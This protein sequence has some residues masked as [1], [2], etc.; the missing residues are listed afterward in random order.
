M[1]KS[2]LNS[3]K[4]ELVAQAYLQA[5][6]DRCLGLTCLTYNVYLS[7]KK[8][9]REYLS[10]HAPKN[11]SSVNERVNELKDFEAFRQRPEIR[12]KVDWIDSRA[13]S[14]NS[15]EVKGERRHA[16]EEVA[17]GMRMQAWVHRCAGAS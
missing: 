2:T 12:N 9:T 4:I 8:P 16:R 11:R 10:R 5:I 6:G 13:R 3:Q 7:D 15:C 17:T 14:T 1:S